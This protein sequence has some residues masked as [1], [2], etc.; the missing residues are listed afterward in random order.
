MGQLLHVPIQVGTNK[1][2]FEPTKSETP[3]LTIELGEGIS[4]ISLDLQTALRQTTERVETRTACARPFA[5]RRGRLYG[6]G[7][8]VK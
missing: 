1:V 5:Q 3:M 7:A 6:G 8:K 4:R 2:G